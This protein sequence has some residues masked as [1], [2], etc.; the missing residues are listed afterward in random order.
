VKRLPMLVEYLRSFGMRVVIAAATVALAFPVLSLADVTGTTTLAANTRLNLDT[1]STVASGGDLLWNGSTLT[2]QGSATAGVL[3]GLTGSAAY[4]GLTSGQLAIFAVLLS[5][6]AISG[7]SAPSGAILVVHT[8]GGNYAKLLVTSNSGGSLGL[9]YTTYG[10]SGGGGGGGGNSGPSITDVQNAATNIPSGLP[11]GA[12]AQGALFVVKGANLGPATFTQAAAFPLPKSVGGTSIT[13]TVGST[14]VDCIMFYSL[15]R[16]VSAILP[17]TTPTGAGTLK[18]TYN[19]QSASFQIKIVQNNI[20]IYTVSQSGSGDAIA[21]LN[22]DSTLI[23]PTHAANAG[24]VLVFWGTGLGPVNF[25]ETQ[26]ATQSDMSN[27]PLHVYIGGQEAQINFRGRNGCCSSADSIYVTVPAGV[28][29]CAVSVVMQIGNM[30]SNGTSIAVGQNGRTCTPVNPQVPVGFTGTYKVGGVFLERTVETT[31]GILGGPPTNTKVDAGGATFEKIT[32]TSGAPTGAQLDVNSYGSCS[33]SNYQQGS[34]PPTAGGGT[35]TPLDAGPSITVNGPGSFG[36]KTLQKSTIG[37][38]S[39]YGGLFDQTATTLV[40]GAYMFTGPGGA[41]VGQFTANYTLPAIFTWTDQSTITTVN[42]ASGVT[43]HWTGGNPSGYVT[44]SGFSTYYGGTAAATVI[45]S[46]TCNARVSD[47][48]FT[49]PPAVLLALPPSG[50]STPG[51]AVLPGSLSV[52]SL[53]Y[54]VFGPPPGLDVAVID[55]IFAY[56][57]SVTYQ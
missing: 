54:Q 16:Q 17:S 15:A 2:P 8:N 46:F 22:S 3:P 23:S 49:V 27:V 18:L 55:S 19:G 11:N 12:L 43:V 14:T 47:G 34:T 41:D 20:G 30:V 42:R 56:G 7:G 39:I 9:Q 40:P 31:A 1:G 13:V 36:T 57:T 51:G 38:F 45:A 4:G 53:D 5:S 24:D 44:I 32:Y 29:G 25:D 33:I 28:V 6:A 21:F 26:P 10:A 35:V 52:E 50:S 48:S 37:G